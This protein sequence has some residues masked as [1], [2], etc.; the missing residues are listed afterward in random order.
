MCVR[1][2]DGGAR[3][4]P[5]N[6]GQSLGS[7]PTGRRRHKSRE[8][9]NVRCRRQFGYCQSRQDKAEAKKQKARLGNGRRPSRFVIYHGQPL[10]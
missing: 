9:L 1:V 4:L 2:C 8:Q 5:V 7:L 6:G 3:P 10:T